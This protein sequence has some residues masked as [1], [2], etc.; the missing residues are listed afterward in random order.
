MQPRAPGPGRYPYPSNVVIMIQ[1]RSYR[2]GCLVKQLGPG[3]AASAARDPG[4]GIPGPQA[5][6]T[7]DFKVTWP[8]A[9]F[10]GSPTRPGE[11]RGVWKLGV[12]GGS[13]PG[14]FQVKAAGFGSN[15]GVWFQ[16][17]WNYFQ[18]YLSDLAGDHVWTGTAAPRRLRAGARTAGP[19]CRYHRRPG[20]IRVTAPILRRV[21]SLAHESRSA[22]GTE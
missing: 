12:G 7:N 14:R 3:R 11:R 9:R 5:D 18:Y 21:N 4:P 13:P 16:S 22:T 6:F 17:V 19:G 1:P 15:Q 20:A 10:G 8:R 2:P